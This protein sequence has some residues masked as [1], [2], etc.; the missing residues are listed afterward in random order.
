MSARYM[1]SSQNRC[2]TSPAHQ[3]VDLACFAGP[4]GGDR[5]VARLEDGIGLVEGQA[6]RAIRT[7]ILGKD[8]AFGDMRR[9]LT[10]AGDY[11]W[12]CPDHYGS[13]DPGLPAIPGS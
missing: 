10:T 13:Y 2:L 12:I 6:M 4:V 1:I 7:V 8:R 3:G 9:V 11:L 5:V